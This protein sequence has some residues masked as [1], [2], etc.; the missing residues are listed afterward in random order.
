MTDSVSVDAHELI[1]FSEDLTQEA[2]II[3]GEVRKSV[4]QTAMVTKRTWAAD[5][6]RAFGSLGRQYAP[7]IDYTL[8]EN[9]EEGG[10]GSIEAE[11]GPNL[12]RYGGK[13]GAGGLVPGYGRFEDAPGGVRGPAR[14][15]VRRTA[16][17]AETEF[18]QR[19]AMAVE[20][21]QQR[22]GIA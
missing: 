3:T 10:A 13:T 19:I 22:S 7:T 9:G 5:A 20:R 11:I 16:V 15:S 8:T 2:D 17:K 12:E 14:G 21:S 18:E 4:Q 6:R 1:Q